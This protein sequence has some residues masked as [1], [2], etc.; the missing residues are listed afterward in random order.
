[1][2]ESDEAPPPDPGV[3]GGRSVRLRR[4]VS[5]V[6]LVAAS[7]GAGW[8]AG[9]VTFAPPEPAVETPETVTYTVAE[10]TIGRS[11]SLQATVTFPVLTTVRARSAGIV[12]T[13]PLGGDGTVE[14]G[15]VLWTVNEVPTV[16]AVGTVPA[17]R[18]LAG[19][20]TGADVA[21]LQAFLTTVLGTDLEQTGT[22]DAAT[23]AAVRQWQRSLG[24]EA[25]GTVPIDRIAWFPA[26]PARVSLADGVV[27]GADVAPGMEA[28]LVRSL[29]P[30]V[31]LRLGEGQR[32]LV[33]PGTGTVIRAGDSAWEGVVA[34][35]VETPT[36]ESR[37]TV[38]APD[39]G[40][41]C[42]EQ[43]GALAEG[44]ALPAEI[45][46]VPETTG[47]AVPAAAI[48]LDPDGSPF[49]ES[50]DGERIDIVVLAEADGLAVVDGVAE[51]AVPAP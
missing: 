17:Y 12:T 24:V 20:A 29:T 5:G 42:G 28:F 4:W 1:M 47:P 15:E 27:V 46:V 22:F 16:A 33:S 26:L 43:C 31:S 13:A 32:N 21:Q 50:P 36:G 30:E 10:K 39:G 23:A 41:V 8:W 19:G 45:I 37:A 35:V 7:L 25:T 34:D 49:V 40:P 14:V 51:I 3:E 2:S 38:T 18:D 48:R 9:R 11:M 44:Q 6:V